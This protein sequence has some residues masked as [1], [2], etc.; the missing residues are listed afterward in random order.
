LVGLKIK[1]LQAVS[2]P[3]SKE[4]KEP[5]SPN[6]APSPGSAKAAQG[7]V[8]VEVFVL[9]ISPSATTVRTVPELNLVAAGR[10][11]QAAAKASSIV[12]LDCRIMA[13]NGKVIASTAQLTWALS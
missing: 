8:S 7:A 10:A 3:S 2:T 4:V 5:Q 13:K 9:N 12:V 6:S 11:G 1:Y